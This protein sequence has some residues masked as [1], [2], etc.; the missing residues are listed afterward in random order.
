MCVIRK[1]TLLTNLF[2][3]MTYN[4]RLHE[5]EDLPIT[6]ALYLMF[7]VWSNA[8][9]SFRISQISWSENSNTF[10]AER[11]SANSAA[12]SLPSHVMLP[13]CHSVVKI[14]SNSTKF[15]QHLYITNITHFKGA[16]TVVAVLW[17][18][19]SQNISQFDYPCTDIFF[20]FEC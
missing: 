14:N 16:H 3:A 12:S 1:D 13:P 10:M 17:D 18:W 5:T 8:A 20:Y 6:A 19:M 11:M 9:S 15:I 2:L 4:Q 7:P